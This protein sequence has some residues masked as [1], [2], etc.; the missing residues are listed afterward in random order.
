MVAPLVMANRDR[1]TSP[2]WKLVT[3]HGVDAM[4]N[5]GL[6]VLGYPPTWASTAQENK[7]VMDATAKFFGGNGNG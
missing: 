5:L 6:D 1:W 3:A 7:L 2:L 4:W